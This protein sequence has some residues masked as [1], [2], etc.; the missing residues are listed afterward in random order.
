V[1]RLRQHADSTITV[2]H[3]TD[4]SLRRLAKGYR[5]DL[6][7]IADGD[8]PRGRERV[9]RAWL[10]DVEGEQRLRAALRTSWLAREDGTDSYTDFIGGR[11]AGRGRVL[12]RAGPELR[13]GGVP[14]SLDVL[15]RVRARVGVAGRAAASRHTRASPGRAHHRAVPAV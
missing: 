4:A 10:R 6:E 14:R 1:S 13:P 3:L 15:A 11:R 2:G 8:Q 9:V 12:R 5:R 7:D